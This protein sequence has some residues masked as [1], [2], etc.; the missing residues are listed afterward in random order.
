MIAVM[1]R[2]PLIWWQQSIGLWTVVFHLVMV[3][4]ETRMKPP[5]ISSERWQKPPVGTIKINTDG[6]FSS[7]TSCPKSWF[8]S[9][10]IEGSTG[11][12]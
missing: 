7:E 5:V 8:D 3:N 1:E 9:G 11:P 12:R 4:E 10:I 2:V 6:A